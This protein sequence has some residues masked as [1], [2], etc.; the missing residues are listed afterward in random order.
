[1]EYKG[2]SGT[3]DLDEGVLHGRVAGLRDVIT[4][5]GTTAAGI[6]QAF[7]DSVDDYLA[8]CAEDGKQPEKPLP[9]DLPRFEVCPLTREEGG[10]YLITFP[11]HPGCVA[12]GE[13]PEEAV[14]KGRDA[15]RS[16]VAAPRDLDRPNPNE[17]R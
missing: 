11:D 1:M 7:R 4:F 10:G 3:L 12:Y 6:E 8:F 2:Y 15:L 17:N 13:T 14:A 5:E 16:H 9:P